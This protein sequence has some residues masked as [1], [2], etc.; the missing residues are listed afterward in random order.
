VKHLLKLGVCW[1][2][3]CTSF[4]AYGIF[5]DGNGHYGLRPETQTNP[6]FATDRGLHQGIFQSFRLLAEARTNDN[7][8]MNLEF[9]VFNDPRSAYMGDYAQPADCSE[10]ADTNGDGRDE[11]SNTGSSSNCQGRHQDTNDPGYEA[12]TPRITKLYAKYAFDYCIVE[13]G[14][15]G[16]DWGMGIFLDS[17]DDPFETSGSVFDGVTCSINIQKTQALGFSFGFDKLSETGASIDVGLPKNDD[18]TNYGP[19]KTKDDLD[20]LFVTIEYND[21]KANAGAAF[22]R[23]VGIYFANIF[24]SEEINGRSS[25]DKKNK[26]KTDIKFADLYTGFYLQDF[27]LRNEILFRLGKSTDPSWARY[28]G[29]SNENGGQTVKS[30]V[31]SIGLAG[32]MTY[33][34]SRSG[35]VVGPAE[36]NQGTAASHNVFLQYAYAPGD[37]DGYY[38][39]WEGTGQDRKPKRKS[40]SAKAMAFNRNY[41]PAMILFNGQREMDDLRVDG[42][43]DPS[44][45]MNATLVAA[46]YRFESLTY[47]NFET[48][49]IAAKLNESMPEAVKKQLAAQEAEEK[50]NDEKSY[51][52]RPIG[53]SGTSLGYELDLKYSKAMGRNLDLGLGG[54]AA[55]PGAAWRVNK[56]DSPEFSYLLQATAAYKF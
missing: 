32:D 40:Q 30:N 47:G 18:T 22:T 7:L 39:E 29:V 35:S 5:L 19:S 3:S 43:F 14:R 6:G 31:D 25:D 42:I 8:S 48:K 50:A 51:R 53:Y 44:R 21:R 56:K 38:P 17:G 10:L 4:F 52:D 55:L 34:I 41:K 20:Q 1:L 46:G 11:N 16:R 26:A 27:I 36:F 24:G 23:Q 37:R 33:T 45:F 13:A 12:Y 49:F 54:A 15:R 28:G 9:R 2:A